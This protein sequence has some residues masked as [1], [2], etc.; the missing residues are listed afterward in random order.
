MNIVFKLN[1][2]CL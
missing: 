1:L 2:V